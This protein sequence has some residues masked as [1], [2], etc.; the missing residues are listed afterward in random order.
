M[1]RSEVLA[2]LF[3]ETLNYSQKA[4]FSRVAA[5]VHTAVAAAV[6]SED[7]DP[8][9]FSGYLDA[10]MTMV[11]RTAPKAE[12]DALSLILIACKNLMDPAADPR[13]S[14]ASIAL[15]RLEGLIAA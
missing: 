9:Y 1:Q 15:I 6:M 4:T 12:A 10:T 8:A 3:I 7:K 11:E 14:G 13:V 2:K 5:A